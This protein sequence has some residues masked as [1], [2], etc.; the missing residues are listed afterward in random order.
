MSDLIDPF[1]KQTEPRPAET[2]I[3]TITVTVP[4]GVIVNVIQNPSPVQ[5]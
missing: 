2:P 3:V 4:K 1:T 5:L